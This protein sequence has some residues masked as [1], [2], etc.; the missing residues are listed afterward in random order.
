MAK[1]KAAKAAGK[2]HKKEKESKKSKIPVDTS[3]STI[4]GRGALKPK[5]GS[6]SENSTVT[7]NASEKSSKKDKTAKADKKGKSKAVTETPAANGAPAPAEDLDE[8]AI[9]LREIKSFGGTEEDFDLL[10]DVDTDDEDVVA[11]EEATAD[12]VSGPFSRLLS[13][14]YRT[15]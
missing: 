6:T 2:E 10:K 14:H 13:S 3:S 8:N 4:N 11:S 1:D 12:D 15:K 9:L 5:A 7:S